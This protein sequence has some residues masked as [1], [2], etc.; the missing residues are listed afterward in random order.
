MIT[1][2]LKECERKKREW[3]E[4]M[5]ENGGSGY[6]GEEQVWWEKDRSD[7]SNNCDVF[8]ISNETVRM[9]SSS[10]NWN[11]EFSYERDKNIMV[12]I[13]MVTKWE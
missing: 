5:T 8:A 10:D 11:H 4:K 2:V 1:C 6:A 7:I 13:G 9:I 12:G 3:K